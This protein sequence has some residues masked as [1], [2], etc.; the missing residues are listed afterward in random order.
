MSD[1]EYERIRRLIDQ[2]EALKAANDRLSA[3]LAAAERLIKIMSARLL[4][5]RQIVDN[6]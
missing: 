4:E 6:R 2:V 3:D 1:K 5:L